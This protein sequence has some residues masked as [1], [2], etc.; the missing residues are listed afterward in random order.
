MELR[1]QAQRD[2]AMSLHAE[3][4]RRGFALQFILSSSVQY[5]SDEM[6]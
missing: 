6:R 1:Q 2:F 3:M 5:S 4:N